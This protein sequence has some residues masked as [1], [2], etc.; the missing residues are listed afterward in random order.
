LLRESVT[1]PRRG[2]PPHQIK[3]LDRALVGAVALVYLVI[4]VATISDYGVMWDCSEM[5]TGDRDLYFYLTLDRDYLDYDKAASIPEYARPDHPDFDAIARH[6]LIAPPIQ[7]PQ[8]IWPVG[9]LS[10]SLTKKIFYSLLSC[11]GPIEA[12]H[13]AP[14]L[15]YVAFLVIV[16]RFTLRWFGRWPAAVALIALATYPRLIAHSHVNLKD[17]PSLTVFTL[18]ITT[19]FEGIMERRWR[20][21][22]LSSLSWGVALAT[23]A[24]A[25]FLPLI[26]GAWF[27]YDGVRRRR[28]GEEP[29]QRRMRIMLAAYPF[30]GVA[31]AC[32]LWPWL[33]MDFPSHLRAHLQHLLT[34]GYG[35]PGHWQIE[36][37]MNA[38]ITMPLAVLALAALGV[39]VLFLRHKEA[40]RSGL[41]LLLGLWLAIPILRVSVPS[42]LNFDMIRR[43]MEFLPPVGIAAGLGAAAI[44]EGLAVAAKRLPVWMGALL[45]VAAFFGPIVSWNVRNHPHQVVF[46]NALVGGLQGAQRRGL[47]ESTDYWGLATRS[48]IRWINAHAERDAALLVPVGHQHIAYT[49]KE[50]LRS[51][52]D[53]IDQESLSFSEVAARWKAHR[54]PA[55]VMY[56]TRTTHYGGFVRDIDAT[57]PPVMSITVDGGVILKILRFD[58]TD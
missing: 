11:L 4:A 50:W 12:H 29:L 44:V 45:V 5:L 54:G 32:A 1:V 48:G 33:F 35:G 7:S 43:F 2:S 14:I 49:R 41:P 18:T 10:S 38:V 24:N 42:A 30:A 23:K 56:L 25:L 9:P 52:I 51:D 21:L 28:A 36:P 17:I 40:V 16:H 31:V 3:A 8:D 22:L 34:R 47:P 37:L 53:F 13:L 57:T 6:A 39:C 26:I 46:Y 20:L 19:F 55:Y 58:S 27:L 15:W